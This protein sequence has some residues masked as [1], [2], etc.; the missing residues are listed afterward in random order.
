MCN[1]DQKKTN[2]I[3]HNNLIR[4]VAV[5]S[6]GKLKFKEEV[7]SL[8]Q[9]TLLNYVKDCWPVI[10]NVIYLCYTRNN[11]NRLAD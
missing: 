11:F 9:Q 8:S 7:K 3:F 2:I 5:N 10:A 1:F 6:L 4:L